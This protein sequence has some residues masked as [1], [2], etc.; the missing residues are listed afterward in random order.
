MGKGANG[1]VRGQGLNHAIDDAVKLVAA[2][3]AISEGKKTL[4]EAV[5]DYN[6]EMVQR[7]QLAVDTAVNE[8]KMVQDMDKLK[9]MTVAKKGVTK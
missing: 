7:G 5:K 9:E 3:V 8:G 2:L 6:T 4:V 1:L